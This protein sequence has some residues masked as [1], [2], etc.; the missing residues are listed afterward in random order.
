MVRRS[1]HFGKRQPLVTPGD[2]VAGAGDVNG[3]LVVAA[4]DVTRLMD[5]E[6]FRMQGPAIKLEDQFSDFWSNGKHDRYLYE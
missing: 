6:Q 3:G 1:S 4:L 2:D 5:F